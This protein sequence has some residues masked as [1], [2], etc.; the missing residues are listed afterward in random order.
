M[1]FAEVQ[2]SGVTQSYG[3]SNLDLL[4]EYF[5]QIEEEGGNPERIRSGISSKFIYTSS[6][7]PIMKA[8]D[9]QM[10]RESR[11]VPLDK[12]QLECDISI[13]GNLI[14]LLSLSSTRPIGITIESEQMAKGM[15]SFF[16]LA[17][18][19]AADYDK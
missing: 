18:Q 14:A 7:G 4:R 15:K 1:F 2:K 6:K 11:F 17:W 19:A 5:P 9:A 12:F 10:N 3:V 16:D 13:A 8:S